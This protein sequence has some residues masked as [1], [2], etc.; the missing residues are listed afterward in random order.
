MVE[1]ATVYD[2]AKYYVKQGFSVI[3]LKPRSKEPLVAWKQYQERLPSPNELE[4]W[5]KG[6]R[7][8]IAIVTGRVSGNLVVLDFDSK[9]SFK[10][11]VEKLRS[12]SELLRIDINNTWIVETGKGYH[13]YLRLPREDLVPSTKVRLVEGVDL[14]A[15]GGY[16]VAPPSVHPSGKQYRFIEVDGG[17]LGPPSIPEPVELREEEWHELLRLLAPP[18]RQG[19]K[20]AVNVK[21]RELDDSK[22]LRL[23]ELLKD[24]WLEG[25]RQDLALFM[26]GWMAKARV[27]PASTARLFRFLA[28]ERMDKELYKRLE[29]IYYSYKKLYG[30][31]PELEELDQLV[32]EWKAQGILTRNV[33]KA[34]SK[35]LEERVKGKTG[36]QEILEATL[37]EE[38]ALEIIR[39]IEE[40]L[41]TKS[42][43]RDSITILTDLENNKGYTNHMRLLRI[44]QVRRENDRIK[45]LKVVWEGA[46]TD[47][48]VYFSPIGDI[49]KY[50]ITWESR[51]RPKPLRIGP[52]T[53]EEIYARLR[54]E[55]FMTNTRLGLEALSNIVNAF[56]IKG[57][58]EFKEEVEYPGFYLVDGKIV[59]VKWEPKNI[60][61]DE[62]RGALEL[63][64]ELA[65]KWYAKIIDKFAIIIKWGIIHPFI[66]VRKQL[67]REYQV[68][69]IIEYGERNTGKTTLG[70]IA[71][72][73]LWGLERTKHSIPFSEANTEARFGRAISRSTF[74]IVI[75]ECNSI[76]YKPEI[77]NLMKSKVENTVARGKYERGTYRQYLA[78]SPVIYTLNPSPR[79]DFNSLELVPKTTLLLEFTTKDKLTNDEIQLFRKNVE[80]RLYELKAIGYWVASYVIEKGPEILKKDWQEL[81]EELLAEAYREARLDLPDWIKIRYEVTSYEELN[82]EK[83]LRIIEHLRK[84]INDLYAKHISKIIV[85]DDIDR[86]TVLDYEDIPLER[87]VTALVKNDLI[88]WIIKRR[89]TNTILITTGI[90]S[91]IPNN[92][93]VTSLR[94]LA[95]ILGVPEKYREKISLRLGKRTTSVRAIELTIEELIE[96]LSPEEEPTPKET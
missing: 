77:I 24:A 76:F 82:A 91:E 55:G 73:Y 3:P 54:T 33:S 23:K 11:F 37:G 95:E 81:A 89:N 56:I 20:P 34:A 70:E 49:T 32:E 38:R 74:G 35:E 71:T 69:D 47:L 59:V 79:V 25:Q 12:A 94:D 48:I 31:I 43:F 72:V 84:T 60:T 21:L 62:L 58:A 63:L 87:K 7:A 4:E 8:N 57:G 22:L 75:N 93:Q 30:D 2:Y 42:P 26:S 40:I 67:G 45:L 19:R 68:P 5:F 15:E 18:S 50:E 36:V 90:L 9:D 39:E 51:V 92:I 83:R 46:I 78:L 1:L 14:K 64:N 86:L 66:F 16:V 53:I 80:P 44:Y 6:R 61:R 52:A 85:K 10:A 29:A 88:P 65:T 17:L 27:H 41:G 28:E 96:L 13:V